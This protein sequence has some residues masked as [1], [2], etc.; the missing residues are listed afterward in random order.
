V[1]LKKRII[2]VR[3]EILEEDDGVYHIEATDPDKA[4]ETA[5]YL[6]KYGKYD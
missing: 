4:V 5:L 3:C 6:E 2:F 1:L